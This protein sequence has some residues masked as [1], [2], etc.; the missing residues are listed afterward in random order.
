MAAMNYRGLILASKGPNNRD[1]E[2]DGYMNDEIAN[3][4]SKIYYESFFTDID[5]NKYKFILNLPNSE[6]TH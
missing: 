4:P 2:E 3:E 6:V 1:L 5:K